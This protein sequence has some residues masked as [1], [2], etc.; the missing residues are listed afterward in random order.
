MKKE[1][2]VRIL[3]P[4]SGAEFTSA[5][6]AIKYV[7]E[8]RARVAGEFAIEFL[9]TDRRHLAVLKSIAGQSAEA[10]PAKPRHS[11]NLPESIPSSTG[12]SEYATFGRYP[13]FPSTAF[14]RAA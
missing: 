11:P 14:Q 9:E 7:K 12:T 13:M 2:Q 6:R 5:K 3:N 1:Q 4:G 10:A 8:G